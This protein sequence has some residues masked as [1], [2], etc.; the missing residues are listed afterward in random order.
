MDGLTTL[1]PCV[2]G[3]YLVLFANFLPELVG[4]RIQQ[5]LR[6]SM[7]AKHV[8]G[9]F[10]AYFLVVVVNPNFADKE[11]GHGFAIT[12]AV[13]TWFLITTRA[14]FA[15]AIGSMIMLLLVYLLNVKKQNVKASG[16]ADK[17]QV[18]L[19]IE[20]MQKLFAGIGALI[21][22][23]GF[24]VYYIEKKLEYGEAFDVGRF[25]IGNKSCKYYTPPSAR[26]V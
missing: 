5:V 7:M 24:V 3:M 15:F 11:L 25:I 22:V 6:E 13:Y 8:V 9:L 1:A 2:F 14:P 19:R 21:G 26:I 17:E 16:D 18:V 10:L 12:I 23:V 20:T 4:C